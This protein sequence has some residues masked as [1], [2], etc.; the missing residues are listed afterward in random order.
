MSDDDDSEVQQLYAAATDSQCKVKQRRPRSSSPRSRSE[1]TACNGSPRAAGSAA[2]RRRTV[3][4]S[5]DE[6]ESL[7]KAHAEWERVAAFFSVATNRTLYAGDHAAARRAY[8]AQHSDVNGV[9]AEWDAV[10]DFYNN[11]GTPKTQFGQAQKWR[12]TC[13]RYFSKPGSAARTPVDLKDKWR[14]LTKRNPDVIGNLN[15]ARVAAQRRNTTV[16]KEVRDQVAAFDQ[17]LTE[18]AER[19][20]QSGTAAAPDS[21]AFWL[22]VRAALEQQPPAGRSAVAIRK[23]DATALRDR[24]VRRAGGEQQ[25][26]YV[27]D[28]NG[29]VL[30]K[31]TAS[32]H[33]EAAAIAA[34]MGVVDVRLRSLPATRF[35]EADVHVYDACEPSAKPSVA[36]AVKDV[37]VDERY[38][39]PFDVALRSVQPNTGLLFS[40]A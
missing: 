5:D 27:L 1:V 22:Q 25:P 20:E 30:H 21:D 33:S 35:Q 8:V 36:Y 6:V 19:V 10:T 17:A 7:K 18:A 15:T 14:N 3:R 32:N 4:W 28:T 16:R 13:G 31:V 37:P 2:G 12:Y 29:V 34:K 40:L 9:G 11:D 39:R 24:Y 23:L 38:R 26:V